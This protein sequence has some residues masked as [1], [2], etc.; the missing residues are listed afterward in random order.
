MPVPPVV[1]GP[2]RRFAGRIEVIGF[3]GVAY[4]GQIPANLGLAELSRDLE[5]QRTY[6][7]DTWV[8][9]AVFDRPESLRSLVEAVGTAIAA[10]PRDGSTV[11][12][13]DDHL[14]TD[15]T[16]LRTVLGMVLRRQLHTF[17]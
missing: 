10:H 6:V 16:L 4:F 17:V 5:F 11:L 3:G 15:R 7:F 14:P 8:G 1:I 12:A 13:A 2:L 9:S